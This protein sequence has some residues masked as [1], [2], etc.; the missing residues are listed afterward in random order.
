MGRGSQRASFPLADLIGQRINSRHPSNLLT[1][2]RERY[3]SNGKDLQKDVLHLH[4][5]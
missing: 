4:H 5:S 1:K 3:L 2:R